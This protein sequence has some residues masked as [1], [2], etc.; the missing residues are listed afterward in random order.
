[1]TSRWLLTALVL[2][3]SS[4]LIA[5]TG[6]PQSEDTLADESAPMRTPHGDPDISG[7]F[8][9]RTLTPLN[10]PAAVG[11]QATLS[12]EEAAAFEASER[13]RLNR[14]LFD[15][16]SGQPS[17]GYQSRAEGGVLSYNEFW[18]ERGIELTKDNRTSL[19]VD[20][21]NGRVP[22]REEYERQSRIRYLNLRNGFGDSYTD[23]S[24][25]D[26]CLMGFNSGPPMKS[27]SYNN[28]VVILQAP[29]YVVIVNEMVHNSRIIP[30][31]GRSHG[32]LRQYAGV[33]RG[34]WEGETLVV[35]TRNFLR[36]TSL[37]GTTADTYL[38]ERFRRVN[39]DTVMYEFTVDD[40]NSFTQPWTATMPFRRT[41]GPLY[42]Y[43]CH[44]G[45]VGLSGILA[46][47]RKLNIQVV[48]S[49]EER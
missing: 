10:R 47:A 43:A 19:V 11:D 44:E 41:D 22:Y 7:I 8:T 31:D 26:R 32:D 5:G 23:R 1:M 29:G 9:F 25:A 36:E 3:G 48:E 14:D 6:L 16:E 17:A 35:E 40:P 34:R 21:P 49:S 24:L 15:P 2:F 13:Q 4:T 33:S 18:Y 20:P 42:E 30:L 28:N 27:G 39:S 38:V 45:N 37:G 46:G 12:D